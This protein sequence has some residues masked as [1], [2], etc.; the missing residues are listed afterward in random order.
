[1]VSSCSARSVLCQTEP[2]IVEQ[3]KWMHVAIT[4]DGDK[5]RIYANGEQV[6][7]TDFQETRG[8]NETYRLGGSGG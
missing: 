7:E 6:A 3:D 8:I 5:F 2:G 1:M 4:G